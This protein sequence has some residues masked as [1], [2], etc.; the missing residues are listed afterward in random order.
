[1]AAVDGYVLEKK[2]YLSIARAHIFDKFA[3]HI[4]LLFFNAES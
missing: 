1:M 4:L 2:L 3:L